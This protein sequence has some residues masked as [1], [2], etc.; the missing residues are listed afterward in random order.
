M[1]S[2]EY[3]ESE[4]NERG[5]SAVLAAIKEELKESIDTRLQLFK[6]ELKDKLAMMKV[7]G[8]LAAVA[9]VLIGTAYVL[10]TLA[11]V[12]LVSALFAESPYRWCLAFLIVGVLW[13][14]LGGAAG[15]FAKREYGV[16]GLAPKRTLT[17]L[18][19]DKE[20]IEK[21]ATRKHHERTTG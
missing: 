20:W 16:K 8:P 2:R 15:Y 19:G 12:G 21:E 3:P 11:L 6:R 17:V 10:L 5:V 14:L 1:N 7:V 18:R 9:A 4:S 13:L